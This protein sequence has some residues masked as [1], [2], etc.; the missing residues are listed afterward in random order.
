MKKL[1]I[2]LLVVVPIVILL[3]GCATKQGKPQTTCPVM[4]GQP[5]SREYHYDYMGKRVF[6]CCDMCVM[7]FKK[8]Q[9]MYMSKLR[10][11]HVILED[12]P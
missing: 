8:N 12:L 2:L 10:K 3:V 7:T 11:Q 1:V 4:E 6:F 5:I 9:E